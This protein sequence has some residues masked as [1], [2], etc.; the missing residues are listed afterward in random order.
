MLHFTSVWDNLNVGLKCH[1]QT[2]QVEAVDHE[3]DYYNIRLQVETFFYVAQMKTK[4][5][6]N[7]SS[8]DP[9]DKIQKSNSM[10]ILNGKRIL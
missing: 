4:V 8:A 3:F 7:W 1:L 6:N 2:P 5:E 10:Q 9:W